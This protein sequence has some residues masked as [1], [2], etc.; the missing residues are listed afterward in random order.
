MQVV[1]KFCLWNQVAMLLLVKAKRCWR[2]CY[3]YS[4]KTVDTAT[5]S[6]GALLINRREWRSGLG[7]IHCCLEGDVPLTVAVLRG[8]RMDG[9]CT[10]TTTASDGGPPIHREQASGWG[11]MRCWGGGGSMMLTKKWWN[12]RTCWSCIKKIDKRNS[13]SSVKCWIE[14]KKNVIVS[15]YFNKII[16]ASNVPWD[17]KFSLFHKWQHRRMSNWWS[18]P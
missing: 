17:V 15:Q 1:V 13:S 14:G 2:C 9:N 11:W 7:W 3:W 12:Y 6:N 8:L 16:F 5:A 10:E 18:H 4:N